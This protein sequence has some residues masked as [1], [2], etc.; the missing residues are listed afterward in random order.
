MIRGGFWLL[1]TLGATAVPAATIQFQDVTPGSGIAYQG[2]S[3]GASWGNLDRDIYPD[4]FVSNH[5]SMVSLYL[6]N[7]QRTCVYVPSCL[8]W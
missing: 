8:S 3:F 1:L 2:E 5:R 6:P 7:R 4:L